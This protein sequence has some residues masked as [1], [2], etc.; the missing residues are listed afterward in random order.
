MHV[1]GAPTLRG[2]VLWIPHTISDHHSY[3]SNE[4]ISEIFK[5]MF[6]DSEIAAAFTCGKNKTSYITKFSLAPY[7]TKLLVKDVNEAS[8]GFVAMFDESL[9]KT[10][11]TKQ[12]DIHL[13]YWSCDHVASRYLGSQFMGHGK[14]KDLLK[15]CKVSVFFLSLIN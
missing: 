2:E 12:M 9:N 5:A 13:H 15:H 4:G 7:I 3:N 14:A 1:G 10:T 8:S 11:K 6:D